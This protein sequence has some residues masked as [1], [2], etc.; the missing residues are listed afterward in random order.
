MLSGGVILVVYHQ[1]ILPVSVFE[2]NPFLS[3]DAA[4]LL[5]ISTLE[6]APSSYLFDPLE[7]ENGNPSPNQTKSKLNF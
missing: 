3:G 5:S 1:S 6:E 7:P 2:I 4:N